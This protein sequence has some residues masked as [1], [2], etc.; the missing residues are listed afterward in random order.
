MH[1]K[2]F[3][4]GNQSSQLLAHMARQQISSSV[5]NKI[6]NADETE[7]HTTGDYLAAFTSSI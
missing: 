4:Y 7:A 2:Y 5:V 3:E 1:S 6:V